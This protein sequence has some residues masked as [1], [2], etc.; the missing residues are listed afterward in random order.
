MQ[1]TNYQLEFTER[2]SGSLHNATLNENIPNVMPIDS[3]LQILTQEVYISF[4]LT[5][6]CSTIA[7]D[8]TSNGV[9][10]IFDSHAR[11]VFDMADADGTYVLLE[12]NLINNLMQYLQILYK[13]NVLFQ[14]KG[15]KI[16]IAQF[17]ENTTLHN[18]IS[19]PTLTCCSSTC[20]NPAV[21]DNLKSTIERYAICFYSIC[22]SLIKPCSY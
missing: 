13:R 20:D 4:L 6:G 17:T 14:L 18:N 3:A 15:V 2:Y 1:N 22:F 7:F 16:A 12:V 5:I 8:T 9:L 11:D 19:Q 21:I 10:K